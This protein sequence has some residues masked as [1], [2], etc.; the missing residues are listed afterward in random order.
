[1]PASLRQQKAACMKEITVARSPRQPL[2]CLL[3]SPEFPKQSFWNWTSVC[4]LR[5]KKSMGPPLGLLTLAAILP[6]NWKFR[7]ADLNTRKLADRDLRW[8]DVVCVG[9]MG[10]QQEGCL[11]VVRLAHEHGK[12]VAVGGADPTS[13]PSVYRAADALVLGEA[14]TNVPLWLAAWEQGAPRGTFQGGGAPDLGTSPVPRFDLARLDDYLCASI[15]FSRGCPFN[16]EFCAVTELFGHAP[17]TKTPEQVCRELEALRQ[18][19]YR[20]WVDFVDDNFI[21]HKRSATQM[22]TALLDWCKRRDYPFFFST[23]VSLNLAEDPELMSLMAAVDFRYV[24]TGI[25][26]TEAGALQGAQKPVNTRRPIQ[27][28]IRALNEHGLLVTAGFVLGFDGESDNAADAILSCVAENALP[29]AMVSLLS[30]LP[31]TQLTRRLAEEGR[32][33]DLAGNPVAPGEL[34]EMR[35]DRGLGTVLD[36]A[37]IGLNFTTE[38]DRGTI[39]K[40]QM[41][42]V[43]TLYA[44]ANF[45]A[46]ATAAVRRI[47]QV[48][49]HQPSLSEAWV[50]LLGFIRLCLFMTRRPE[51]RRHFWR[52][53]RES[54]QLGKDEFTMAGALATLYT[55]FLHMRTLFVESLDQ[56]RSRELGLDSAGRGERRRD[57]AH[58]EP[59]RCRALPATSPDLHTEPAG[60]PAGT[61]REV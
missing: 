45:M 41:R 26:T 38:R 49:K 21:G 33:T 13:Q 29:V 46:R 34:F 7:L 37:L 9:G 23:E 39:L 12:F 20:G 55:H 52:F 50:D 18:L 2:R 53:M 25:E 28:R 56:R 30:A 59:V 51:V 61:E 58:L 32:L 48:P 6:Q 43:D 31:L 44:P 14:E 47:A 17:R 57:D 4:K 54:W 42:I 35:I 24:F 19:G 40:D 60:E 22:L 8:A 10:I 16:C 5:G 11:E 1:M 3:V 27:E 36:Q 15:Q